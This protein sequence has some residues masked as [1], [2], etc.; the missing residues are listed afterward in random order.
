MEEMD[1]DGEEAV[2]AAAG[3]V[4]REQER[5]EVRA[6]YRRLNE[7]ICRQE[8]GILVT[9]NLQQIIQTNEQLYDKVGLSTCQSPFRRILLETNAFL[10]S[11]LW[12][13]LN[14]S[15]R[16]NRKR[17]ERIQRLRLYRIKWM[18]ETSIDKKTDERISICL[19]R[20]LR[21]RRPSPTQRLSGTSRGCARSRR[22]TCP[23]TRSSSA[24]WSTL[25]SW[26][27]R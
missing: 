15:V 21:Y 12:K 5:A 27:G 7:E 9:E 13:S 3:P 16:R 26:C 22:T 17:A 14:V 4:G 19:F 20:L 25:R 1:V 24:S 23:P 8:D 2:G 11:L 10:I 18:F 6:G